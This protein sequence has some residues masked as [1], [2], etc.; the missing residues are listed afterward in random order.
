MFVRRQ[1][2][3]DDAR[4]SFLLAAQRL[5]RR[6]LERRELIALV[7]MDGSGARGVRRAGR[8]RVGAVASGGGRRGPGLGRGEEDGQLAVARVVVVAVRL[9]ARY[10]LRRGD[11]CGAGTE[12]KSRAARVSGGRVDRSLGNVR[13]RRDEGA[14]VERERARTRRVPSKS[15]S[16][17]RRMLSWTMEN[18][19]GPWPEA[20]PTSAPI[21]RLR[22]SLR[23]G[24][25][26]MEKRWA[27]DTKKKK[28]DHGYDRPYYDR[29]DQSATS[30]SNDSD[31]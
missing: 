23:C 12:G 18:S 31:R 29:L 7:A 30:T 13:R 22:C 20:S 3:G 27:N 25:H 1:V 26:L 14:R 19:L 21:A 4:G 17:S 2:R 28:S 16:R 24:G 8:G 5:R 6:A 9:Y 10:E 11:R 15:A